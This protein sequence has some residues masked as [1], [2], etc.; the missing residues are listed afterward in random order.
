MEMAVVK[1]FT[2]SL[3]ATFD[4]L[5]YYAGAN[6]LSNEEVAEMVVE[7]V[8]NLEN[9]S[10]T[11]N[12]DITVS[13]VREGSIII[14]YELESNIPGVVDLALSEINNAIGRKVTVSDEFSLILLS[15]T[16]MFTTD[17]PLSGSPS[18][19]PSTKLSAVPTAEPSQSQNP[20]PLPTSDESESST[21]S[22]PL[23]TND[24]TGV[25]TTNPTL[26]PSTAYPTIAGITFNVILSNISS[27][28]NYLSDPFGRF[29]VWCTAFV[30]DE[31]GVLGDVSSTNFVW[32]YQSE[33]T[34]EWKNFEIEKNDDISMT[35]TRS[36]EE[37]MSK[38]V[39]QSIRRL[40]AGH[41][42][43]EEA[44]ASH[45]FEEDAV[46]RLRLKFVPENPSFPSKLSNEFELN[47]NSLPSGGVC[48]IQNVDGLQPLDMYYLNC[49]DSWSNDNETN[50]EYNAMIGDV[51]MSTSGFVDDA[52]ELV[53]IAP[54]GDLTITILVKEKDEY[55]AI[56]CY[57]INETF[58][59]TDELD[60]EGADSI[61]LTINDLTDT[62]SF[63][64]NPS[65]AVSI[66]SV[67]EYLF[68]ESLIDQSEA[69]L[70]VDD[71]VM[72]LLNTSTV[73][74]PSKDSSNI[75]GAA[76]VTELATASAITSNEEIVAVE[77]T[78]A[79]LVEQYLIDIFEAVDLFI[80]TSAEDS[81][82]SSSSSEV[83]D[84]LYSIGEQSQELISNLEAALVG[85][86]D[87]D[88]ITE[89]DIDSINSLSESLVDF[90]TLAASV[91]LAE[92][93][94]GE[95]FNFEYIEYDENGKVIASKAVSA[96]KFITDESSDSA[97]LCGTTKQNIVLSDS[98][99]TNQDGIFYCAFMASTTNNFVPKGE[100]N[101]NRTQRS[102]SI[103]TA[104]I[105]ADD[106]E[107]RRRRRR[108]SEAVEHNTSA[109]SPYLI[110]MSVS[111]A[112]SFDLNMTLEKSTDFPSCDFWN[113]D[114]D[115]WD[116]AGCFVYNITNDSVICGCTHLTT[117]SVSDDEIIPETNVLTDIG[118][119]ELSASNLISHP[120]VII[121]VI[122]LLVI[123]CLI[124]WINPR[125]ARHSRSI[126]AM[127][128]IIYESVRQKKLYKDVL[129]KELK[130]ISD[131]IP[132]EKELG[133][134]IKAQLQAN[135]ISMCT[136]QLKLLKLYLRNE[137]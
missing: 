65:F 3:N 42:V 19:S 14:D 113:I 103:V 94:V 68:E 82:A 75:T 70:I 64:E 106:S 18:M 122:C 105:Y 60:E 33:G 86:F 52:Q 76:I 10:T 59:F 51:T 16:M 108:L 30:E 55:N 112:S 132:N 39:V 116:T 119:R 73:I 20:T 121:T 63:Y 9:T 53:G 81:T 114:D 24:S 83:Q 67:V 23:P 101:L 102:G 26:N 107:T 109:C 100:Q 80:D 71:M 38:L 72:N 90:A 69:A 50:L 120:V 96:V 92:S 115:Y 13:D 43:D 27:S 15:N 98:F 79:I 46:D 5:E 57:Q 17:E 44:A 117:F 88:N 22:K 85:A 89:E 1:R 110:T 78:T 41:C 36:G 8:M 104:N 118:W 47:T 62:E 133:S 32:Q 129:G 58:Q 45:P 128:D 137:V 31:E 6:N 54:V 21:T 35:V 131:N 135:P 125:S 84:V 4:D 124:C 130:I 97:V 7:S 87:S 74:S 91:A 48:V 25:P 95:T 34:N 2:M 11:N 93:E 126:L 12:V 136:L 66:H 40:N 99:M 28:T 56:T 77:N 29:E 134:G 127:E 49:S 61:L 37:Y 123:F 111:N